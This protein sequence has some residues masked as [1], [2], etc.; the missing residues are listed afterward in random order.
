MV[1]EDARR[2]RRQLRHRATDGA[3][4]ERDEAAGEGGQILPAVAKRG[5]PPP[6][7]A[8]DAP[9]TRGSCTLSTAAPDLRPKRLPSENARAYRGIHSNAARD[10]E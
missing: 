8:G 3:G 5:A 4:E 6:D 1:G 10:P 7:P 9:G 2:V